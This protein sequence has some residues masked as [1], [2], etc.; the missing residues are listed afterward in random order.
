MDLMATI[1]KPKDRPVMVTICGDSGTGKTS[2]AAT[3]PNPI[4]IRAEDGLQSVPADKRPDAFPVLAA[5]KAT[6]TVQMLWDQL[7]ALLQQPHEY[8][9]VVIDSV[10]ALER[11]FIASVL[12]SDHKAKSINQALG[13]YGAG[14][15]AVASMHQRVRKAAGLLNER[16]GM[17]VVFVAHADV[18]MMR[19]PDTDDYMRYS[20]RLPSKSMPPYVDDVD[21]V[22]FLKLTTYTK[23]DDGDRKKAISTGERELIC[24]ATAANVSKNRFGIT[25]A[26]EV[27]QGVNPLEELIPYLRREPEPAQAGEWPAATITE[28]ETEQE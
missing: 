26:I 11:L 7:I 18:E 22:G 2:L 21:L 27:P 6:D 24:Y 16:R 3:F 8:Q 28:N 9:T 25:E 19:L 5:A 20:L 4:F 10:T 15:A 12:E 23:G 17:H 1:A 14:P 13:G